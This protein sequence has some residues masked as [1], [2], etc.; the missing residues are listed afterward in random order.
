[1][2]WFTTRRRR[3]TTGDPGAGRE[4]SSQLR[5]ALP[6]R[7]EAVGEALASGSGTVAACEVSGGDLARD[8]RT[9]SE[10][11]DALATTYRLVLGID[12]A[13][14]ATRALAIAWSDATLGYLN[15][16]SC[17]D[18]LTGLASRPHLRS[19]IS[20]VY[21]TAHHDEHALV[22]VATPP[23][24]GPSPD[25]VITRA[26]QDARI[27]DTART[28]FPGPETIGHVG[29]GRVVVL[30]GR[31]DRIGR[32]VGLLRRMLDGG[33]TPQPRVWI[34]GLPETD[35]AAGRLLD[36]LTRV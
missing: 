10:S 15:D 14:A 24:P 7:F 18:P 8:G 26:L 29:P 35:E 27:G 19:R 11:L 5:A 34:E 23:W 13:H 1:M 32:R 6:P 4:L 22:V 12:P 2:D 20:E 3:G 28:V 30:A 16:L 17:D 21:R 9:L 25:D 36:E 33:E 31:D